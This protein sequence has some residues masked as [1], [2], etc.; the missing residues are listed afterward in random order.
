MSKRH[1]RKNLLKCLGALVNKYHIPQDSRWLCT[2]RAF[3]EDCAVKPERGDLY[4]NMSLEQACGVFQKMVNG[5]QADADTRCRAWF[6]ICGVI[7][8]AA[9]DQAAGLTSN[10]ANDCT[11]SHK[12]LSRLPRAT[13]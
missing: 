6:V 4:P 12:R 1:S 2:I 5:F 13:G 8:R 10:S 3:I 9:Q 11:R 7:G